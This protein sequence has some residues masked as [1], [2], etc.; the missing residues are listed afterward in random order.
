M[1]TLGQFFRV[2]RVPLSSRC[3][4]T[5]WERGDR[6]LTAYVNGRLFTGNPAQIV[7][8][9]H[10]EIFLSYGTASQRPP[11]IPASYQFPSGE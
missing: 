1:F 10:E 4:G 2:W 8:T 5:Y 7:L 3:I 9:Q 11:A 6:H